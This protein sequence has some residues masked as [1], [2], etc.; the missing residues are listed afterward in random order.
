MR[1]LAFDIEC[2]DG[3]H[4]CEFGYV[5]TDE[6]FNIIKKSVITINPESKFNLVGRPGSRDLCL[7]FSQEQY[8][9]SPIFTTYYDDIKNLLEYPEQIVVGH[10]VGND[11]DFLR[12]ACKRY[13]LSPINFQF[14]DS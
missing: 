5:V 1:Y 8:Y 4:I 3:K 14:F 12:T 13:N 2:C 10:A 11:A 9:N 7:S 6:K